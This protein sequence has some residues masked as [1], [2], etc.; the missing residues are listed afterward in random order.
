MP[1]LVDLTN[2]QFGK[3]TVLERDFETQLQRN[4]LKPMW[5]CKC[6]CGMKISVRSS[7]LKSGISASCGCSR[8]END[9][10][11]LMHE[12]NSANNESDFR[13]IPLSLEVNAKVDIDDYDILKQYTWRID[14][15]GYASTTII[16]HGERTEIL[17]HNLI[18]HPPV[19]T[20]VSFIEKGKHDYRKKNLKIANRQQI[21]FNRKVSKNKRYSN[22]K[23]VSKRRGRWIAS[24]GKDNKRYNLGTFETDID[25][26]K[27]YNTKAIELFGEFAWLNELP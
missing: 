26:A 6:D 10:K 19:G 21:V 7:N 4:S 1:K 27:A 22:Y 2:K 15:A 23:G 18:M 14:G 3:L 20:C 9:K 25:A 13:W 17:M 16:T 12:L 8:K 5:L 24:I 11:N